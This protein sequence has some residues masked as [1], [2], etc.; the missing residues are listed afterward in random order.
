[1]EELAWEAWFGYLELNFAV[2]NV[3]CLEGMALSFF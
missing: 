1:M 2:H 3:S